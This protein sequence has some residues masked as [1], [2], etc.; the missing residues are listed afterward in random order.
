[1]KNSGD[2]VLAEA[3]VIES[4]QSGENPADVCSP[5]PGFAQQMFGNAGRFLFF[6][7]ILAVIAPAGEFPG[8]VEKRRY[9]GDQ[10]IHVFGLSEPVGDRGHMK[11]VFPEKALRTALAAFENSFRILDYFA[12]SVLEPGEPG[13][14][15]LK[16][17]DALNRHRRGIIPRAAA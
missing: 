16:G 1:M 15:P 2:A 9:D 14:D 3:L 12:D 10:R 11:S 6:D 5:H 17:G 7:G 13:L 8:I 4:L